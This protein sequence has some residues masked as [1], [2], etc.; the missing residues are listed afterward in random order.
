MRYARTPQADLLAFALACRGFQP[1]P[2]ATARPERR[3]LPR[4][5]WGLPRRFQRQAVSMFFNLLSIK[6]EEEA[7]A[8]E[9]RARRRTRRRISRR[10][11][12]RAVKVVA[13]CARPT[14][15][16]ARSPSTSTRTSRCS[17]PHLPP[18][19]A[20]APSRR[21][22][23]AAAAL[24]ARRAVRTTSPCGTSSRR[25][26][27]RDAGKEFLR[28]AAARS[29]QHG[30]ISLKLEWRG[31]GRAASGLRLREAF[32]ATGMR[33]RRRDLLFHEVDAPPRVGARS[34]P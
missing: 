12:E 14:A 10:T 21:R 23:R 20:A 24:R 4:T 29:Q 17:S 6:R 33:D 3:S 9:E 30:E 26:P 22:R 2:S 7:V 27:S 28:L 5:E 31:R 18:R 32:A 1:R 8:P 16:S 19:R 13:P 15:R 34:V 25:R 11:P